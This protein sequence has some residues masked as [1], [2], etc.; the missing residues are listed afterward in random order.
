MIVVKLNK[1]FNHCIVKW[2]TFKF[3][4]ALW[5]QHWECRLFF[6]IF[7]YTIAASYVWIFI[8][9]VYLHMLI[10]V[11]V[12]TE[13]LKVRWFILFGWSKYT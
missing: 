10:F 1:H 4:V 12:Y 6:A 3:Y 13:R 9:A 2:Q 7:Q 11:S 5:F 8:E